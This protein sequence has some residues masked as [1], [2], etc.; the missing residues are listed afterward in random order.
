MKIKIVPNIMYVPTIQMCLDYRRYI[1]KNSQM[2]EQKVD[3]GFFCVLILVF[4]LALDKSQSLELTFLIFEMKGFGLRH[5]LVFR[6]CF[7][8][9]DS[10]KYTRR[11][12][13]SKATPKK[14]NIIAVQSQSMLYNVSWHF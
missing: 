2:T 14:S 1:I 3:W 5:D 6:A 8:I 7:P 11:L 13:H 10:L 12:K 4:S 9:R